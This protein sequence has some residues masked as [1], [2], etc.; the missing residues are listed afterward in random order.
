MNSTQRVRNAI[1]GLPT[2]RT[3]LYAWVRANDMPKR[4]LSAYGSL[5]AFEDRYEMDAAHLFD[6]V[7]D[8]AGRR[9]QLLGAVVDDMARV[10]RLLLRVGRGTGDIFALARYTHDLSAQLFDRRG[11]FGHAIGQFGDVGLQV[12]SADAQIPRQLRSLH[13]CLRD[14]HNSSLRPMTRNG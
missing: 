12:E 1:L 7:D 11:L 10:G 9:A 8:V 2:D 3:P 14:A 5:L 4:I 13:H 6:Q